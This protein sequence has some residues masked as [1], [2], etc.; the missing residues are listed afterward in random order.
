V[1]RGAAEAPPAQLLRATLLIVVSACCFGSIGPLTV[2]AT[3]RGMALE[4]IQAWRYGTSALLLV[5]YGWWRGG[6]RVAGVT[7]WWH[8][9]ILLIAGGG[10]AAVATL[11]LVALRWIP[12][13][14]SSFLFYTFPAWVTLITALRGIE[15]ID[16]TRAVALAL[17]LGG[18]AFMVG[19]PSS[20]SMHPLGVS[21]VLAG[22]LVYALYI[23]VLSVL[24]YKRDVTDLPRAIA[25]GGSVLF[26]GWSVITGTLF[27]IP[28]LTAFSA[29]TLQGLLS[30]ISFM[31][32]LAGLRVLGPV[33]ASITSTVEPFWTTM[34]GILLLQQS[35]GA[36][37]LLGG[38]AIMAA[39][40]LLQ[41]AP[42]AVRPVRSSTAV[43]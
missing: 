33:R 23:P 25:V 34:I 7:P 3:Q 13:A 8:P 11:A 2:M 43:R 6:G 21:A 27:A 1:S 22:A 9:R 39:V 29:S 5:G 26:I 18:I 31:C 35:V 40:L 28:D 10:Q 41:R 36:G 4:S 42:V 14:T 37:T 17:A 16:R 32:F 19:A 24:Q 20:G 12:A 38:V 15:A 30:A